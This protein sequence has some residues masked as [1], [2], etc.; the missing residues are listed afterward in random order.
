M[1][2]LF[3]ENLSPFLPRLL[4]QEYPGSLHVTEA[5]LNGAS[6]RQIWEFARSNGLAILPKDA[7]FRERSF[8]EVSPPKL[9]WLNV[10][11]AGTTAIAE[12]LRREFQQL[13]SFESQRDVP[14]LVLSLA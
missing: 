11:N 7:D 8:S 3:D 9:I 6:D 10:R 13:N 5:G 14:F 1:R 4:V 2:L 12:L